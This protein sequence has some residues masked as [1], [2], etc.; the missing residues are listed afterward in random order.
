MQEL[1]TW[2]EVKREANLV[3][4]G[5]DFIDADMVLGSRI[6]LEVDSPRGTEARK[7]VFAY[8]TEVLMTLT[9]VYQPLE[10]PRIISF[11]PAK[12]TEREA[13]YEWLENELDT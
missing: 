11:R 5:L 8:V 7:Q 1:F 6:K 13:Y 4:H 3:K 9:V 12:R 2:D 10:I